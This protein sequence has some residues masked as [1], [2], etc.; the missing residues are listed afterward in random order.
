MFRPRTRASSHIAFSRRAALGLIAAGGTGLFRSPAFGTVHRAAAEIS[1][2]LTPVVLNDDLALLAGLK[3]Y[4]ESAIG[5]PVKLSLKRTYQE[6]T[7]LLVSGQLD[8]AWICGY[9]YVAFQDRLE[10]VAVPLWRG[11]PL[12]QS[13]V[14]VGAN[15]PAQ[16]FDDLGG[17]VHA[18]SDP[19]SN[20][21]Y[22]VTAA[23][24]A[25]RGVRPEAFFNRVFFTYGHR[26]VVRAVAAGLADSGSVD[27]Y[28]WEV[29]A[30]A[31]PDMIGMTRVIRKS[32]PLAFPPVA[33]LRGGLSRPE[34]FAL[35]QA[36]IGMAG[37]S[38]G[39]QVL[40]LLQL[41][42]FV[43]AKPDIFNT[44]AA[45]ADLVRRLG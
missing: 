3:A 24:L 21:G 5:R 45:K 22:L 29:M 42:G 38:G 7:T 35:Q 23:G 11:E 4:L 13:Y 33:T 30:A 26:N 10:L 8:A 2:G 14:I 25:E 34:V 18:F 6:I 32:E 31:E 41:D 15:S 19:D 20:S 40:T 16:T 9:P 36:F 17:G 28:V 37:N 43:Q 1:V 27:G 12:Y 44:I 39:Q